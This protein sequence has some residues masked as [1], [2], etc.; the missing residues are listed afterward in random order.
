MVVLGNISEE[1]YAW[2]EGTTTHGPATNTSLDVQSRTGV[3]KCLMLSESPEK[4]NRSHYKGDPCIYH[5]QTCRT[6][7]HWAAYG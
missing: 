1:I 6:A 2:H 3:P 7:T 4:C 5:N